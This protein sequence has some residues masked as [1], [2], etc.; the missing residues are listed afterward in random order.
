[1]FTSLKPV[2][3]LQ[4]L[5]RFD[6]YDLTANRSGVLSPRQRGR[7]LLARLLE[8]LGGALIAAFLTLAL[9][10]S[11]E[12]FQPPAP[13]ESRL[14]VIVLGAWF[15]IFTLLFILRIRPAFSASVA[16]VEGRVRKDEPV[17]LGGLWIEQICIGAARFY[18]PYSVF[19][20]LE[21]DATY[22]VY[23]T[24]R[25]SL[26]GGKLLLSAELIAPAPDEED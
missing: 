19:D 7:F 15:L 24:E 17:P 2:S 13:P 22:K 14:I 12:P 9:L 23:Y 11:L 4:R 21:E 18:V 25:G 1:M 10:N 5:Q 6:D 8:S 26:A 3:D 16:H 20:F